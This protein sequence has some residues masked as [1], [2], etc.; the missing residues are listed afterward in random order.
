MMTGFPESL[1]VEHAI[2]KMALKIIRQIILYFIKTPY[3]FV[4]FLKLAEKIYLV[5]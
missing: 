2:S 3:F 4:H 5:K 1:S